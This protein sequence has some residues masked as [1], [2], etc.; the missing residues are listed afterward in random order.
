MTEGINYGILA[1]VPALIAIGLSIYSKNVIASLFTAVYVGSLIVSDYHPFTAIVTMINNYMYPK[2][3]E[4]SNAQTI[5]MMSL[6]GGFIALLTSTGAS[7]SFANRMKGTLKNR[8]YGETAAYIGGLVVWFTDT[9]NPLMTGPIFEEILAS[10]RTSKEKFAYIIDITSICEVA[11]IPIVGWGVYSMGL[12]DTQ[13]AELGITGTTSWDIYL[14]A[15]PYNFYA[16]LGIIM[17]GFLCITQFDYGPMLKAQ[18][19]AMATGEIIRKGS[20]PMRQ[21]VKTDVEDENATPISTMVIP[22]VVMVTSVFYNLYLNGFPYENIPGPMIRAS[23]ATGFMLATIV[24][25]AICVFRNIKSFS[26]CLS[27]FT[28]G[29]SSTAFMSIL[30]TL[31]WSLGGL[32]SDMGTAEFIL[33]ST[34]EYLTPAMLPAVFF[35]IGAIIS[36]ATGTSWGTMA[37]LFPLAIPM[38]HSLGVELGIIIAAVSSGGLF[39][40]SSSPVSDTTM[41]AATG[42]GGD[43]M[44][45]FI[46]MLPYSMTLGAV[47]FVSFAV[48]GVVQSNVVLLPAI[49]SL[50]IIIFVL[51]KISVKKHGLVKDINKN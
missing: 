30:L 44:D 18:N 6:I 7:T 21:P 42:A 46:A 4:P 34:S 8:A 28:K 23:I 11:L 26:D 10:L 36:F 43:L 37:I 49:A 38:A 5:F 17:C 32:S 39:G 16:I 14:S 9:G 31:A 13:L 19:R 3:A 47:V 12:I 25:I 35:V 15:I 33:E 51:H 27:T 24:L 45:F 50:L 48:A 20:T 41:L 2:I 29:V 40:D 1:I 22:L